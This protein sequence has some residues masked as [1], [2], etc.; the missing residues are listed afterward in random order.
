MISNVYRRLSLENLYKCIG[1]Y[2]KS[3]TFKAATEYNNTYLHI[4]NNAP[5][6]PTKRSFMKQMGQP[7]IVAQNVFTK[8]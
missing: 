3:K 6:F 2:A 4:T 7:P 8:Q 5:K 1:H